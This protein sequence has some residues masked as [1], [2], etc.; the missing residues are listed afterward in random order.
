MPCCMNSC[1]TVRERLTILGIP[2]SRVVNAYYA[3]LVLVLGFIV[4]SLFSIS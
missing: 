4:F 3:N 2:R 1:H